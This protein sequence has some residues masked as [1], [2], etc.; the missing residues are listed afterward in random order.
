MDLYNKRLYPQSLH[1]KCL[2]HLYTHNLMKNKN[3]NNET[4]FK[5][6]YANNISTMI[7][8]MM[9]CILEAQYMLY[10]LIFA[11]ISS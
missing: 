4:L 1:P 3:H 9:I 10:D 11:C 8:S 2:S 5:S 7:Q 6:G